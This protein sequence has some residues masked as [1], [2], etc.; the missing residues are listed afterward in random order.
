MFPISNFPSTNHPTLLPSYKFP[1]LFIIFG[2]EPNLS[3]LLQNPIAVVPIPIMR[4]LN[5]INLLA[6]V[7]N[8]FLLKSVKAKYTS[9]NASAIPLYF[10]IYTE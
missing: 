10:Q 7:K 2:V 6:S 1:L 8:N 5:K 9:I 4:D 3:P